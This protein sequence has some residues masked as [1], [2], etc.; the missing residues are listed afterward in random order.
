MTDIQVDTK[1]VGVIGLGAMGGHM[2]RRLVQAGFTVW[3]HDINAEAIQRLRRDGGHAAADAAEAASNAAV[4]LLMVASAAQSEQVLF[5]PDGVLTTLPEGRTV[6]VCSTVPPDFMEQLGQRLGERGVLLL[7]APVSGGVSGAEQGT[8]T[9][10]VA[11]S[12]AAYAACEA[13]LAAFAPKIYRLGDV[14]GQGTT[15]KIINQLLVGVHIATTVEAVALAAR[16]GVD[17]E[18]LYEVISNSSGASSAFT[19]RVPDIIAGKSPPGGALDIFVKDLSIV[20]EAGLHAQF[21]LPMTATAHQLFLMGAAAGFGRDNASTLI[22][23]FERLTGIQVAA[24]HADAESV[25]P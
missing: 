11:G 14:P 7:D 21:P 23:V 6:M 12:D 10:M 5:G 15:V 25:G 1:A 17:L 19:S 2:A 24:G 3:G 13:V 18:R 22:K 8:L 16:L 4:V 20:L 9:A